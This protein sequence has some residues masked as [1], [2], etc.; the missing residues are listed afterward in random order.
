MVRIGFRFLFFAK[1]Q[2]RNE[3]ERRNAENNLNLHS[4]EMQ[5]YLKNTDFNKNSF[6]D[7]HEM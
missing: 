6:T 5:I 3:N 1:I 2:Q 4:W 7:F